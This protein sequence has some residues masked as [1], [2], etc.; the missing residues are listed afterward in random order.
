MRAVI[1]LNEVK[2]IVDN[3]DIEDIKNIINDLIYVDKTAMTQEAFDYIVK[4][5]SGSLRIH[6]FAQGEY[7]LNRALFEE[8]LAL[9]DSSAER[10]RIIGA[11]KYAY[12]YPEEFITVWETKPRQH[13]RLV[14][15]IPVKNISNYKLGWEGWFQW[16]EDSLNYAL[17]VVDERIFNHI[18]TNI[19]NSN[20]DAREEYAQSFWADSEVLEKL[21][22]DKQRVVINSL[23]SNPSINF[24][25][26]KYLALNHKTPSIRI[27]IASHARDRDLLQIIWDS[28]KSKQIRDAVSKNPH[29]K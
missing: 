8:N 10:L 28:T 2:S 15:S 3:G 12:L 19:L 5:T 6:A 17:T 29:F 4:N 18:N 23:A 20:T 22:H 25:T 26:A 9:V 14:N 24:E 21:K 11:S 27:S 16:C 7:Y 13:W 1:T